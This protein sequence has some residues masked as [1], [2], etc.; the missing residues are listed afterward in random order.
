MLSTTPVA[1]AC[2]SG[3]DGDRLGADEFG[4]AGG[5]RAV[6]APLDALQIRRAGQWP[7]AVDALRRP[8]HAVQHH[9][10]LLGQLL[11]EHRL[12]DAPQFHRLVVAVG[13][14][15]QAVCA[16][17]R[18]LVLEVHEQDFA[19]LCLAALHGTL[20]FRRLEQRCTRMNGDLELAAAGLVHIVG[21]CHE[22]LGVEVGGGIG[23]GQVPLGL[24]EGCGSGGQQ[25][26][27]GEKRRQQFHRQD[28]G[29]K[30][31][32]PVGTGMRFGR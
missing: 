22:V 7:L 8:G 27:R 17:D 15:G 25:R 14:E 3:L 23:A 30:R 16:E 10:A 31:Y 13:K 20:D 32:G 6:G 1:K 12:L 19:S 2:L 9:H 28:S 11:L 5:G 18:P 4:D 26:R 24:C 29:L 21:E